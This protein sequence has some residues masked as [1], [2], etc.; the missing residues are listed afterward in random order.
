MFYDL[1]VFK[2]I[3][4]PYDSSSP[5][6]K[7]FDYAVKFTDGIKDNMQVILCS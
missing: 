2:N 5:S 6:D 3:L 7:A 1:A 4:L